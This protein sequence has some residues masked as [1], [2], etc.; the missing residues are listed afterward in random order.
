MGMFRTVRLTRPC[1]RCGRDNR[2]SLQF[3][4]DLDD[5]QEYRLGEVAVTDHGLK[6]GERYEGITVRYCGPCMEE[7]SRA[8]SRAWFE[9]VTD[10]VRDGKVEV[11]EKGGMLKLTVDDL[12]SRAIAAGRVF[13]AT[14]DKQGNLVGQS[15]INPVELQW[16]GSAGE[17]IEGQL[18]AQIAL[19]DVFDRKIKSAGWVHG[20]DESREDVEVYLDEASRIQVHIP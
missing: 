17:T 12:Q 1:E 3:K 4:T 8:A 2:Q 14:L 6:P 15:F 20:R 9:A 18:T 10:M 11:R 13:D 19:N 5:M 16:L 7:W